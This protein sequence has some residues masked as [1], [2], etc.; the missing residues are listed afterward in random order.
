ME[1]VEGTNA[2]AVDKPVQ[3]ASGIRIHTTNHASICVACTSCAMKSG[4]SVVYKLPPC[5][6]KIVP[7]SVHLQQAETNP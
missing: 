7:C 6:P 3:F 2:V 4:V 1:A 5:I